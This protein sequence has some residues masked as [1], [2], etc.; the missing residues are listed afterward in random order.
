MQEASGDAQRVSTGEGDVPSRSRVGLENALSPSFL[1]QKPPS[2]RRRVERPRTQTT[3]LAVRELFTDAEFLNYRF[4]ALGVVLLKVIEQA[5]PLADQ[6][7]KTAARTV[8]LLVRFKVLRQLANALAEQRD[9]NFGASGVGRVRTI[10][11]N[12]GLFL[13]SG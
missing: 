5:T 13:L 2:P 10:L 9:L 1:V 7:E 3:A 6:H 12:E 4:V 11:T 8:I